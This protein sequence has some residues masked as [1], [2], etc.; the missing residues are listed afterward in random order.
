M[1]WLV[2]ELNVDFPLGPQKMK[3][4]MT[5]NSSIVRKKYAHVYIRINKLREVSVKKEGSLS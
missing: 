3:V 5:N 1:Y 4:F 2:S